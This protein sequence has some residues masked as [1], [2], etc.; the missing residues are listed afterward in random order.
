MQIW[1]NGGIGREERPQ[2]SHYF[3]DRII[4]NSA[5]VVLD[6]GENMF[7]VLIDKLGRLKSGIAFSRIGIRSID[8]WKDVNIGLFDSQR[9]HAFHCLL[10][11][12]CSFPLLSRQKVAILHS[13]VLLVEDVLINDALANHR[14][15]Q[16][17]QLLPLL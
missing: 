12:L 5:V 9:T 16:I 13:R 4:V 7:D 2:S 8:G 10:Q 1:L 15:L 17:S 6:I 14:S 3:E 11:L